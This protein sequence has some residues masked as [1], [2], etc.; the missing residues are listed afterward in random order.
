M[1]ITKTLKS[2]N[3]NHR[4]S[5]KTQEE[6]KLLKIRQLTFQISPEIPMKTL[7][8]NKFGQLSAE[9]PMK[10]LNSDQKSE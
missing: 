8:P 3:R 10:T 7:K 4:N 9:M 5:K 6:E 1:K 2:Q